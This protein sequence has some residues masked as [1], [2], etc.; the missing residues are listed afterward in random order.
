M[1]YDNSKMGIS[2]N[3]VGPFT[4]VII[5]TRIDNI[6]NNMNLLMVLIKNFITLFPFF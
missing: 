6:A 4:I 1:Q 3:I 2:K 5:I